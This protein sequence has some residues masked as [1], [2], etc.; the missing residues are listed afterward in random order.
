MIIHPTTGVKYSIF[1]NTGRELLKQYLN[2]YKYGGDE[3]HAEEFIEAIEKYSEERGISN[4]P[5]IKSILKKIKEDKD[6]VKNVVEEET[7]RIL[8]ATPSS[9]DRM[10]ADEM[11]RQKTTGLPT[12]IKDNIVYKK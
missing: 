4:K 11:L 6:V 1:N 7:H 3:T 12:F 10:V 8:I 2:T 5:L 9:L